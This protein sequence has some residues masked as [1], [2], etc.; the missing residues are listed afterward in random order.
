MTPIERMNEV[1]KHYE[2]AL[3]LLAE[4]DVAK[5]EA[6]FHAEVAKIESMALGLLAQIKAK[7]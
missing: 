5:V 4:Q 1:I 7:I 6:A 2:E 3:T